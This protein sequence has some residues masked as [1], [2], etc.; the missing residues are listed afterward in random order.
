MEK[1]LIHSEKIRIY[2]KDVVLRSSN[3]V[4][5]A[6]S[7]EKMMIILF[8]EHFI[9]FQKSKDDKESFIADS[10]H[11]MIN[12]NSE[13]SN[14]FILRSIHPEYQLEIEVRFG[15]DSGADVRCNQEYK[16]GDPQKLD[17][18]NPSRH[19]LYADTYIG[20]LNFWKSANQLASDIN[21]GSESTLDPEYYKTLEDYRIFS[22]ICKS[23]TKI[24]EVH[25]DSLDELFHGVYI[26]RA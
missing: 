23:F 2:D 24:C 11:Y 14:Q 19:V 10:L 15:F 26:Q 7:V 21:N 1:K 16:E 17:R 9:A 12:S 25:A 20:G 5:L 22:R 18:W 13:N 8:A 4:T 6:C 3:G